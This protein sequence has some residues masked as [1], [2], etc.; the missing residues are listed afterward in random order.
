M[1]LTKVMETVEESCGELLLK[2]ELEKIAYE[3]GVAHK[4][5][6]C[7]FCQLVVRGNWIYCEKSCHHI[8]YVR[9][10][11]LMTQDCDCDGYFPYLSN[12][13]YSGNSLCHKPLNKVRQSW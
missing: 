5:E 13:I 11:C 3:K 7:L 4:E 12:D 9:H 10:M 8:D 2:E 1:A 6:L